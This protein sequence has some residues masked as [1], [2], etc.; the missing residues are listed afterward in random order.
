MEGRGK[1][2]ITIDNTFPYNNPSESIYKEVHMAV[3]ELLRSS[4]IKWEKKRKE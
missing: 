3:V 1:R 2:W 4:I